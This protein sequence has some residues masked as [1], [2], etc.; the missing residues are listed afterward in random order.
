M[1]SLVRSEVIKLTSTRTFYGLIAGAV[2]VVLLGT[3]ST[4]ISADPRSLDG[5]LREQPFYVLASINAGL[6]ALVLGI[7]AFTD[8]FR[9]GTIITTL[10]AS[11]SRVR[12]LAGKVTV[13]ALAAAVLALVT[14]GAMMGTALLLSSARGAGLR[15]TSSDVAG[16]LGMVLALALWAAVGVALGAVVRH[17]VAAIVGGLIWVLV[18]ENLGS[19]LLGDLGRYL[20]GQAA[21]ALA[22]ATGTGEALALPLAAAFLGAYVLVAAFIS[23]SA[24]VRR[25]VV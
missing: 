22:R 2:A 14:E 21:H 3:A 1:V 9:H 20:P 13:A 25:D 4:I 15:V 12:V 7:R 5:P 17:Q 8:E 24:L 6:F 19:S 10:L 23:A 16:M 18:V 11:E